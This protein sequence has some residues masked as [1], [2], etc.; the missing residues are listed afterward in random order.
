MKSILDKITVLYE[1]DD[2]IAINKPAGLVVHSDGKREE[3]TLTDWIDKNYPESK[4]VGEPL[5]LSNSD[6]I[7]RS[8]IVHRIDRET[9][10]IMLIAKNQL[11]FLSLKKQFQDRAVNKIYHA[12]VYGEMKDDEGVINRP[13]GRSKKD[14]RQWSA[15]RGARGAMREAV[16]HYRVIAKGGGFSFVEAIPKTGRTHQ[17]RV[18]FKAIN[19]PIV[20]DSLYAPKKEKALGFDRLALHSHSIEFDLLNGKRIKIIAPHPDDFKRALSL[21]EDAYKPKRI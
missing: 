11:A 6:V 1:D 8:G 16:T 12:F 5:I 15:Q 19:Y 10:G 18:H 14:F 20:S 17:I 7:E 3:T 13:I 2:A 21:T 9:S 4:G